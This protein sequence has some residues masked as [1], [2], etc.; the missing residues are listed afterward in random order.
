MILS[1][2]KDCWATHP[3][4]DNPKI[5][6]VYIPLSRQN[7]SLFKP[8]LWCCCQSKASLRFSEYS[9]IL[10]V[11]LVC[12]KLKHLHSWLKCI[13]LLKCNSEII[14]LISLHREVIRKCNSLQLVG[15]EWNRLNDQIVLII[16]QRIWNI[17]VNIAVFNLYG[18]YFL[19]E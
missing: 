16:L 19:T 2:R 13:S 17:C 5:G 12:V 4:E 7:L 11:L 14:S 10:H 1:Q 9:S 8:Y 15:F 6:K 3:T 18:D